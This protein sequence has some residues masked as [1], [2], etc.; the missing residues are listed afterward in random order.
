MD[1]IPFPGVNARKPLTARQQQVYDYVVRCCLEGAPPSMREIGNACGIKAMNAVATHLRL[2]ERK[3][4]IEGRTEKG[5][6]RSIRPATVEHRVMTLP[7]GAV[8]I[9]TTGP[10]VLTRDEL[11]RISE[12][13]TRAAA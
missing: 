4:W 12:T 7:G 1:T 13:L 6:A 10:L 2:I 3:G 9:R 11:R 5:Q 8:E